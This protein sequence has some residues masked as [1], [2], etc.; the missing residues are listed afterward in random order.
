MRAV[1]AISREVGSPDEPLFGYL[2]LKMSPGIAAPWHAPELHPPDE[3]EVFI[4]DS[5]VAES[6]ICRKWPT[7]SVTLATPRDICISRN[8]IKVKAMPRNAG[9]R[10]ARRATNR[11]VRKVTNAPMRCAQ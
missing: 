8:A 9:R 5:F 6:R 11:S 2:P 4:A 3:G 7:R 10:S 1:S